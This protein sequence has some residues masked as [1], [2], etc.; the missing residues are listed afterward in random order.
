M[1]PDSKILTG[2]KRQVRFKV[3]LTFLCLIIVIL[4]TSTFFFYGFGNVNKAIKLITSKNNFNIE[5]VITNPRIKFEYDNGST[6]D[7]SAKKAINTGKNDF[8]MFDVF[9]F[10]DVGQI[11]AGN[12][13]VTND[14][15]NLSFSNN[16]I[17]IIKEVKNEQ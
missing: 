4:G 8:E 16:P 13:L 6:F 12:L 7:V 10:G 9:A 17:L 2:I 1:Y 14:G 11:S 3:F 15:N 5:K